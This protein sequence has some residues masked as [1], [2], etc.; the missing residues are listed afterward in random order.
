MKWWDEGVVFIVYVF[1]VMWVV[2]Y[3]INLVIDIFGF[4]VDGFIIVI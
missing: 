2:F 1:N 4:C 3:D